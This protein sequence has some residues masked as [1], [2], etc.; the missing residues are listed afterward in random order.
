MVVRTFLPYT[1]V[2][3]KPIKQVYSLFPETLGEHIRKVR[4]E[5][6]L[7]QQEVGRLLGVSKD[8]V[9]FWE[10]GRFKPVVH[11]YPAIIAFLGYYPFTHGTETMG[12]K[13]KQLLNCN[14]WN[15]KKGAEILGIDSG[16]LKRILNGQRT[17][18][19]KSDSVI[20]LWSQLP[21]NLKQQYR[22]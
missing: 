5:R 10:N 17:F 4:I 12:G 20:L 3:R 9:T 18:K 6:E 7:S 22:N 13:L 14:G 21:E 19:G 2:V 8:C 16:T 11:L 1:K 15:H